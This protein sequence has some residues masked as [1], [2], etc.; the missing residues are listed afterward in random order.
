MGVV[1]QDYKEPYNQ[2]LAS[3]AVQLSSKIICINLRS[4]G[5]TK[6]FPPSDYDIS[7]NLCHIQL[8]W[9][10]ILLFL[11]FLCWVIFYCKYPG[12]ED[13]GLVD[14]IESEKTEYCT[15]NNADKYFLHTTFASVSIFSHLF[16]AN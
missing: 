13:E 10:F 9:L 16:F 8:N 1:C 2:S 11:H 7:A 4:C 6:H 14:A 3:F 12:L 15:K 5:E